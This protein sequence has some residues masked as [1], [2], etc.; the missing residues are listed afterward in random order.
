MLPEF[1]LVGA[2]KA[3]ST[4]IHDVLDQHDG[5]YLPVSKELHFFDDDS[6][7]AKG[8]EW[9]EL[10]FSETRPGQIAGEVT[11]AYMSYQTT[12][13][14]VHETLGSDVKLIFTLREPVARAYSEFLHNRRR[15]FFE[16]NFEDAIRWE[17][18]S[19]DLPP[20]DRRKF[21]FI[22][23]GYY[24]HQISRFL[25]VFPRENMFFV[26]LEEDLREKSRQTFLAL[27]D[28]LGVDPQELDVRRR[29]NRAYEPRSMLAQRI[30]HGEN[31][32]QRWARAIVKSGRLR[33]QIRRRLLGF[34]TARRRPPEL[35]QELISRIQQRFFTAEIVELEKILRRDL[36]VWRETREA[37]DR[38]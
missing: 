30:L 15:G 26:I 1:L 33:Q 8:R 10:H 7:Y 20:W 3:G 4:T 6:A 9:Y 27:Q 32:L 12:P 25:K 28:F 22:S 35:S 18:E 17:F 38:G 34:N 36:S 19:P 37:R 23:R 29:S 2:P 31:K 24:A 14:R 13:Q 16:G 5:I 11:P 21:S